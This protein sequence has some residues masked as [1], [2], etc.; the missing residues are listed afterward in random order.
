MTPSTPK[1]S[2]RALY[3]QSLKPSDSLF[4]LYFARPLAAP[5]VALLVKTPI[6]PNQV[7]FISTVVM[8]IAMA[9]LAFIAGPLGLWVGVIG[10]EFSYI[11]DCVDGQLARV[12][13]KTSEVGGSLDFMMDELK[14]YFLIAAIS[15]RWTLFDTSPGPDDSLLCGLS[16]LGVGVLTMMAFASAMSLTRFIRS[17]EYASATGQVQIKHGQ[18]AG[19]GRSGGPLWP[20]KTAARLISQYPTTLPLFAFF[21]ALDIFLYS[22]GILHIL[23]AGQ[24]GLGI[25]IKLGGTPP[26]VNERLDPLE[27]AQPP[28]EEEKES[29]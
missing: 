17:P 25:F 5:I 14:A 4:N 26:R 2:I 10:L 6:T 21:D 8:M 23:Y 11:L 12:T 13:G 3:R 20:V 19:E 9:T 1:R 15:F 27:D 22:Y 29:L 18:S 28:S 7:T 24:A 16:P